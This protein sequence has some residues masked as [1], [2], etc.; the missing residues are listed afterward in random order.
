MPPRSPAF[1]AMGFTAVSMLVSSHVH[2]AHAVQP[3]NPCSLASLAITHSGSC[4]QVATALPATHTQARPVLPARAPMCRPRPHVAAHASRF[5]ASQLRQL[6][7]PGT[8]EREEPRD[9]FRPHLA[10]NIPHSHSPG[11]PIRALM[12]GRS[13]C[14]SH[15]GALRG[16]NPRSLERPHLTRLSRRTSPPAI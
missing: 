5:S 13:H 8:M 2:T 11:R 7:E 10:R 16:D 15:G 9:H 6:L 14:A 4:R 12:R 3:H 1:G